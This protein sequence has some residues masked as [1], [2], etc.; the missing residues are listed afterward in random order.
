ME[1]VADH[2][3]QQLKH[4]Q[5]REQLATWRRA[6]GYDRDDS[7][8]HDTRPLSSEEFAA[9]LWSEVNTLKDAISMPRQKVRNLIG[10]VEQGLSERR[11]IRHTQTARGE[12]RPRRGARDCCTG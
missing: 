8:M 7:W 6:H 1:L 2:R 11:Q 10:A 12:A 9:N 5:A 4:F 3:L